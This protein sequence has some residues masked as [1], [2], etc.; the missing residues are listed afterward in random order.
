MHYEPQWEA[1]SLCGGKYRG[2]ISIIDQASEA[3]SKLSRS[4]QT[5]R[6]SRMSRIWVNIAAAT[7]RAQAVSAQAHVQFVKKENAIK[8]DKI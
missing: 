5:S 4:S 6:S 3:G 2:N 7:A 1:Y 8:L